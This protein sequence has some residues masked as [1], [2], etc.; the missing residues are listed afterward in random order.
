MF[1]VH[2]I[3]CHEEQLYY[4]HPP[5]LRLKQGFVLIEPITADLT[6]VKENPNVNPHSPPR[7]ESIF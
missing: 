4:L 7:Q 5:P 3:Q 2:G 6:Q 1:E